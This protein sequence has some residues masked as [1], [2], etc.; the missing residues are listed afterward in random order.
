PRTSFLTSTCSE[1]PRIVVLLLCSGGS[2]R[3]ETKSA[4][5]PIEMSDAESPELSSPQ[6]RGEGRVI[7][8]PPVGRARGKELRD[9]LRPHGVLRTPRVPTVAALRL[10][11]GQAPPII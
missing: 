4:F 9:L 10:A 6:A 1:H 8:Q 11:P 3:F 5:L 2:A 7:A